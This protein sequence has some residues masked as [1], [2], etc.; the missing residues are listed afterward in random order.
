MVH[1]SLLAVAVLSAV[2]SAPAAAYDAEAWLTDFGQLKQVL[3]ERAPN[4][5][6]S[7][8]ERGIDPAK[9]AASAETA[10][11]GA[12]TDA[13]ARQTIRDFISAFGDGHI[14]VTWPDEKAA[15]SSVWGTAS[16]CKGLGF[17][18]E[19]RP[20]GLDW[21]RVGARE[22]EAADSETFPIHVVDAEGGKIGIL[23]IPSFYEW[24]YYKYCPQAVALVGAP[25][26]GECGEECGAA[27]GHQATELL[28]DAVARQIERLKAEG[29]SAIAVDI[30]QNGGGSLWL[31]PVARMLTAVK[32]KAPRL[33]FT[34][35]KNW[36]DAF[37]RNL[38]AIEADLA[39]PII[40]IGYRGVLTTAKVAMETAVA[41]ASQTCDRSG[42]WI[43]EQP[44]CSLLVPDLLYATGVL[45]YAKPGEYSLLYSSSSL[46]FSS[47]YAYQ[48]GLWRG[49]LYVLM[50]EGSASAAEHFATLLKDNE[51]AILIGEPTFGAG[52]GWMSGG[53]QSVV[54]NRTGAELFVPDCIWTRKD[55]VNEVAGIEPDILVP[56]RYHDNPY[57]KAKRV[58]D[59]LKSLDLQNWS[60]ATP[61][62]ITSKTSP[63]GG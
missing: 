33:S 10:L 24:G 18:D 44:G 55:G 22:L 50:D 1:R 59:V 37:Q 20:A 46:F 57:Q 17:E 29:V 56:W 13:E 27:I 62:Y 28:T 58:I 14:S 5:D 38:E 19:D 36:R 35:T 6:W 12:S 11:A 25:E 48:E 32:L 15:E 26:D 49:P 2:M 61:P 9:L 16:L 23:R 54:L 4:L 51:A 39:N 34:R 31:D 43:G 45:D 47:L 30:T 3:A 41:E 21:G 60:P 63:K 40:G 52:C 53:D 7:A 42:I 8:S